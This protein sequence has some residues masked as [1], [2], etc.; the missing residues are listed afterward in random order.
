MKLPLLLL[1]HAQI[2]SDSPHSNPPFGRGFGA[3]R[4]YGTANSRC[5]VGM[6]SFPWCRCFDPFLRI[7][8]RTGH[9]IFRYRPNQ[10]GHCCLSRI[11]GTTLGDWC[12]RTGILGTRCA[13]FVARSVPSVAITIG[14][15]P[16]LVQAKTSKKAKK[17][18]PYQH[19]TTV[20]SQNG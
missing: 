14:L 8:P 11:C 16:P 5:T 19:Q 1:P 20:C 17:S 2:E 6:P 10:L 7:N 3:F 12:Y 9:R 15:E 18:H 4:D 13:V